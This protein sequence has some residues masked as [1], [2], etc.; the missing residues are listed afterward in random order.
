MTICS[1]IG[2]MNGIRRLC[3]YTCMMSMT[4]LPSAEK[5]GACGKMTAVGTSAR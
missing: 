1:V 5:T 3:S 4:E 2:A